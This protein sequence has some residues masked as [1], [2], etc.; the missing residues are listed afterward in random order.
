MVLFYSLGLI[1]FFAL[2]VNFF[3]WRDNSK[4]RANLEGQWNEFIK[5]VDANDL[6]KN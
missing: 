4:V 3:V 2:I 6:K 1:L 5:A